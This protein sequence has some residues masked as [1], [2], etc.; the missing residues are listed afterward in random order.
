[1]AYEDD[2]DPAIE[3]PDPADLQVQAPGTGE[4]PPI[5]NG[6]AIRAIYRKASERLRAQRSGLSGR[7]QIGSLLVGFGQPT[8]SGRW[9]D[10]VANAANTLLQQKLKSRDRDASR[11]DLLAKYE[12]EGEYKAAMI[13]AQMARA[14]ATAR[15]AGAK[16]D[17]AARKPIKVTQGVDDTGPY[18]I[19][20]YMVDGQTTDRFRRITPGAEGA[21]S[22][23]ATRAAPSGAL[24]SAP[25]GI[26]LGATSSSAAPSGLPSG[27]FQ[28]ADGKWYIRSFGG[29]TKEVSGAS[30][31]FEARSAEMK[32]TAEK[33]A[34]ATVARQAD[35]QT[36]ADSANE[37][38]ESLKEASA[39]IN[40]GSVVTGFGAKEKLMALRMA[41]A[42]GDEEAAKKVEATES[43]ILATG[44]QVGHI[45]TQ[46]GAGT[47]LSDADREFAKALAAGDTTL[48]E[49]T[50]K[51]A[52]AINEKLNAWV[53]S[54]SKAA[55]TPG[56]S[57]AAK[58]FRYDANGRRIAN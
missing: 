3:E 32:K 34:E 1:M 39:A 35:W 9:Q 5:P 30:P 50:L 15:A 12:L 23:Q 36:K 37:M 58:V 44:K 14:N 43:Y 42:A 10:A 20:T 46:F 52:L 55:G 11:E 33:G 57:G 22:P 26:A 31:E 47:G 2:Y 19:E 56:S 51:R 8:Q 45:I 29:G 54:Q 18:V 53:R 49:G 24:S 13:D 41:A 28:G 27:A 17:L 6:E 38:S 16:A 4:P 40:S 25:S 48:N 21:T 7:E